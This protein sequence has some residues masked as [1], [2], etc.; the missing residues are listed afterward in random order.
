MRVWDHRPLL[1]YSFRV[2]E[3]FGLLF[4][5]T[6]VVAPVILLL[7][8]LFR[9]PLLLVETGTLI[10]SPLE[11]VMAWFIFLVPILIQPDEMSS[12]DPYVAT[13]ARW[14]SRVTARPSSSSEFP[15]APVTAMPGFINGQR[16]LS[17]S[18]RLASRHASPRSSDHHS[19]LSSSSSDSS[20]L[21]V[22][23][24]AHSGSSPMIGSEIKYSSEASMRKYE[25]E[26]IETYDDM[27]FG[28]GGG[29]HQKDR[30]PAKYDKNEHG[31]EMTSV[32]VQNQGQVQY[33]QWKAHIDKD[34]EVGRVGGAAVIAVGEELEVTV[35]G[36]VFGHVG[37]GGGLFGEV[38]RAMDWSE[39]SLGSVGLK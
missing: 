10:A 30:K 39:I 4:L 35:V 3:I 2:I 20:G 23:D 36:R 29:Y 7:L 38:F 9:M 28:S 8:R 21:D 11:I 13:V 19:S 12:P 25:V 17:D 26:S 37:W 27:E 34:C 1:G 6:S 31:N 14:R 22:S 5:P 32:N 15:I 18:G 16:F 24:H 33:A